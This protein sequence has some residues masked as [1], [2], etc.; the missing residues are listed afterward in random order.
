MCNPITFDGCF[1]WYHPGSADLGVVL[2][3]PHGHEELC[4]HRHWRAVAHNI[5][6]RGLP[7][8]RFDYPGTGDSADDDDTPG[9]VRAWIQSIHDAAVALRAA[10]GVERIALVGLRIGAPLALAAAE[11]MSD[12]AAI[13]L[14]APMTSGESCVR[15]LRVLAMM[16]T[17]KRHRGMQA[18]TRTG[19]LEPAG[20][21]YT[22]E[23]LDDLRALPCCE[24]GGGWRNRFCCWIGRM[25]RRTWNSAL[26]SGTLVPSSRKASSRIIR[27]SCAMPGSPAI[28]MTALAG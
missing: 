24:A 5:A 20:F 10:S 15:E 6:A 13:A 9:R 17:A 8:L 3:A 22:K 1:G 23:T 18:S 27:C 12:V 16:A 19:S 21:L 25:P 7:V 28:P 11:E 26:A 14:L 4:A 2:C